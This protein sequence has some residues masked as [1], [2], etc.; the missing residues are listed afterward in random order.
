MIWEIASISLEGKQEKKLN[1]IQNNTQKQNSNKE[2]K[3][4]CSSRHTEPCFP[5]ADG[6][7]LITQQNQ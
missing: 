6:T 2:K 4:A 7:F 3:A 1:E 5:N